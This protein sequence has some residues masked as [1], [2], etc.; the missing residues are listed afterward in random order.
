MPRLAKRAVDAFRSE[1]AGREAFIFDD[2][3]PGFGIR[4]MP[5]G[6]MSW[7]VQYRNV[8]GRTRR[9]TL[10]KVGVLTPDEARK[11]AQ[12]KLTETAHGAD[13]SAERTA[14][15]KAITVAELADQYLEAA[16]GRFKPSTLLV[17]ESRIACHVKPL[18]GARAVASLTALDSARRPAAADEPQ[19]VRALPAGR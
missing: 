6:V 10:S 7:I 13:P 9:L 19:A 18:L 15:R 3:M 2:Q 14:A 8:Y 11:L 16:R 12:D 17:D 1:P 4:K 5:S